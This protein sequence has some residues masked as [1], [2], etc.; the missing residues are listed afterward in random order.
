MV[1]YHDN[2]HDSD[3]EDRTP[4]KNN[5]ATPKDTPWPSGDKNV[6]NQE[7]LDTLQ[8]RLKQLKKDAQH[9]QE[10]EKDLQREIRRRQEL[11]NKL[12]QIEANLKTKAIQSP[13]EDNL[14]KDQDPFTKEI[15]KAKISKDFK[16]LDMTLYDGTTDP[17][18]HLSNLRSRM[19]LTD[20]SDTVRYKAFPA[21]LTK[22]AI[23]WFDNLPLRS[24]SSF[25]DLAKKFSAKFSIQKDKTKHAPSL[26]GIK[27][28]DRE[29]LCNY[30][31]RF[32]KACLD[33]QNLPTEAAIMGLING[34][35]EEPFSQSI[36]KKY[37]TSLNE[38][39]ERAEKY[40]NMEENARLGEAS[41]SEFPS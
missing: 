8:D 9:Q 30:V 10:A 17:G 22:I 23:R 34:L 39:Q 12:L 40:I 11:E 18:H 37:P 20:A 41:R 21:T 5:D 31:E 38:I 2:E 1:D 3:L 32:N 15:M 4:H 25:D 35:R 27:Q 19:Y 6:S 14:R 7:A 33:I 13:E 36:S 26:L 28:T 29:S 16:L 24:I